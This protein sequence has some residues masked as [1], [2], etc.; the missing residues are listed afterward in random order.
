MKY[1]GKGDDI[2]ARQVRV[3]PA[4]REPPA[5]GHHGVGEDP[6]HLA[7]AGLR[8]RLSSAVVEYVVQ[9]RHLVPLL[10][11]VQGQVGVLLIVVHLVGEVNVLGVGDC[12]F[13]GLLRLLVCNVTDSLIC[14]SVSLQLI[15]PDPLMAQ[16]ELYCA[17]SVQPLSPLQAMTSLVPQLGK[18]A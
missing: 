4:P 15:L 9:R 5:L 13:L 12:T 1:K 10:L 11:L 7:S 14:F 17:C 8:G 16:Q 6:P 18:G 3:H 2:P